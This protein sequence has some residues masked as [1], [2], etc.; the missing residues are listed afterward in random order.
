[1]EPTTLGDVVSAVPQLALACSAALTSEGDLPGTGTKLM[2]LV[3]RTL[4]T[5]MLAIISGY[6]L[7]LDGKNVLSDKE[8]SLLART[9]LS[10]LRVQVI[11][12][13]LG[14]F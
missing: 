5:A 2:R 9:N 11:A 12:E 10:F 8:L 6:T 7:T 1:M 3:S 4:R 14:E 13:H